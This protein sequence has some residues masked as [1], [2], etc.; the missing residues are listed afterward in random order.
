MRLRESN[1]FGSRSMQSG[2][3]SSSKLERPDAVEDQGCLFLAATAGVADVAS[4][5]GVQVGQRRGC[6]GLRLGLATTALVVDQP[7]HR[8]AIRPSG[9]GG[10]EEGSL[11]VG[12]DLT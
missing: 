5:S 11:E 6:A 12:H 10:L 8:R 2:Q 1:R 4:R 7:V 9:E 3:T